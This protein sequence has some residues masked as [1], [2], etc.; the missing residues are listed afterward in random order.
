MNIPLGNVPQ[1]K[2]LLDRGLRIVG[3][4]LM[5]AILILTTYGAFKVP[6]LIPF[7][8][9]LAPTLG[10]VG[11]VFQDGIAFTK[12]NR[13]LR[14]LWHFAKDTHATF[15]F[16]SG[17]VLGIAVLLEALRVLSLI[18]LTRSVELSTFVASG[19]FLLAGLGLGSLTWWLLYKRL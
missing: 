13:D 17:W 18:P 5:L 15:V 1:P 4:M 9:I 2:G 14:L 10:F 12:G 8:L 6:A 3:Q 11:D 16:I 19:L 7:I